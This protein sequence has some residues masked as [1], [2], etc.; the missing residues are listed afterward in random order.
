MRI[1]TRGQRIV[2][3][4]PVSAKHGA[5]IMTTEQGQ[6]QQ[7]DS[8]GDPPHRVVDG[9]LWFFVLLAAGSALLLVWFRG[10]DALYTA[11]LRS[12]TLLLTV[13]PMIV[14]GLLLGGLVKELSDPKQI[15]PVL[16][17]NS[18]IKGLAL[19]TAL[20]AATPGGPFAAFPIVY[21]LALAGADVG[22][23]VAY[24]TAWSV[25]GLHRVVIWELPLMGLDFVTA[26]VLA[27]LPLPLVSGLIARFL[28][29]FIPELPIGRTHVKGGGE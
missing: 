21:A 29:R 28:M 24:L 13:A 3:A 26:R 17:A 15:A 12:A 18:G 11:V 4:A 9:A 7:E 10:F 20:G 23:V 16:G 27:S 19:A 25:L 2:T 22:A 1:A 8:A 6:L 5:A 14:V